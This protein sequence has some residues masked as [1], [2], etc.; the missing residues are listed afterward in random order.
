MNADEE[1]D[2]AKAHSV[3]VAAPTEREGRVLHSLVG[4]H[5]QALAAPA[6]AHLLAIV[7]QLLRAE[8]ISVWTYVKMPS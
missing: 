5:R 8:Q 3:G 7:R 4:I 2:I 6:Q 1:G